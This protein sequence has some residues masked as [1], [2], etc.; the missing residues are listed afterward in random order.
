MNTGKCIG[1]VGLAVLITAIPSAWAQRGMG[2]NEGVVRQALET[3]R[4][5]IKGTVKE[6]ITEKCKKTT[7]QFPVG[8]HLLLKTGEEVQYNVHLGPAVLVK[9]LVGPF[10]AGKSVTVRAFR[11]KK[12]PEGE[13]VA[14][15]LTFDGKK[16]RLR[17]ENLRPV[18]AGRQGRFFGQTVT[19][20]DRPRRGQAYGR[21]YGMGRGRGY[22][23]GYGKGMGRGAGG[24]YGRGYG[25]G[26]G[27]RGQGYRMYAPGRGMGQGRMNAP[28]RGSGQRRG[29]GYGR[30]LGECPWGAAP[31]RRPHYGWSN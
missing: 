15:E 8:T 4:V 23:L 31:A 30:G 7:G 14:I 17:N 6:I 12:M 9:N 10:E 28:A 22:G 19:G 25:K 5:T 29:L 3:Q 24:R 2:D 18:W 26:G 11:T 21:G 1:I 13:F 27:S 20:A 16:V